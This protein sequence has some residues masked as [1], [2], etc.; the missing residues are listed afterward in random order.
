MNYYW[1]PDKNDYEKRIKLHWDTPQYIEQIVLYSTMADNSNIKKIRIKLSDGY[2]VIWGGIQPNGRPTRIYVG[3]H[4]NITD[5]EISLVEVDGTDYGLS[6]VE[7]YGSAT[8][9]SII[10]PFCKILVNDN[11]AYEYL[12][13]M[14]TKTLS[15]DLYC[16][17]TES[18]EAIKI[19]KGN[20]KIIDNQLIIDNSDLDIHLQAANAEHGIGDYVVIKRL[21]PKQM[22]AL[23]K[24]DRRVKQYLWRKRQQQKMSNMFYILSN[25]GLKAVLLRIFQNYIFPRKTKNDE[26]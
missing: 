2:D 6:E 14:K 7:V 13:D 26:A 9:G 11:F 22:K 3:A 17:G 1:Q 20:S 10:R 18:S 5:C 8:L 25:Q 12:C 15:L 16:Y 4:D 23:N 24:K 21:S 19:V